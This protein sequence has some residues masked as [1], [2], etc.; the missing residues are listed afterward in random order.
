MNSVD[1][2][3]M[4]MSGTH[5]HTRFLSVPTISYLI[6]SGFTYP[7]LDIILD[8]TSEAEVLTCVQE[9]NTWDVYICRP[10]CDV[11]EAVLVSRVSGTS[12]IRS[13]DRTQGKLARV[14]TQRYVFNSTY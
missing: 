4:R 13:M 2:F 6:G 14:L 9:D 8:T 12:C 11:T 3:Y 5:S 10:S 1:V 7:D